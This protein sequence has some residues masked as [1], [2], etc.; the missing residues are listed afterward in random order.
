MQRLHAKSKQTKYWIPVPRGR[1]SRPPKIPDATGKPFDLWTWVFTGWRY[2]T[3][4]SPQG[5]AAQSKEGR[6]SLCSQ[7]GHCCPPWHAGQEGLGLPCELACQRRRHREQVPLPQEGLETPA[8]QQGREYEASN[9]RCK[10]KSQRGSDLSYGR[11]ML[12]VTD[13]LVK[14]LQH[15]KAPCWAQSFTRTCQIP[16]LLGSSII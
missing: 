6:H 3:L 13:G 12:T 14:A 10:G 15:H 8:K 11:V 1:P 16:L 2:N 5:I 9:F 4:R 7:L